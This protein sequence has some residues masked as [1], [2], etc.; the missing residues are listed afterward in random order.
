MQEENCRQNRG[1]LSIKFVVL[2]NF[3][4]VIRRRRRR[5]RRRRIGIIH[6]TANTLSPSG[7][8]YNACT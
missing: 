4:D 6:L 2:F 3:S 8:G 5:R 7:N 1:F